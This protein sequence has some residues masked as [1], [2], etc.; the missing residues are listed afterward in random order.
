M[1]SSRGRG[2]HRIRLNCMVTNAE[3]H[4]LSRLSQLLAGLAH[5]PRSPGIVLAFRG[6]SLQK[7]TAHELPFGCVQGYEPGAAQ[8]SCTE[9]R[10][11]GGDHRKEAV[12]DW[13]MH[14]PETIGQNS[15]SS[16][17]DIDVAWSISKS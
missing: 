6:A 5:R 10:P 17:M 16:S 14:T 11:Y 7:G 1:N 15:V 8:G 3:V 13:I 2:T 9:S 12:E 4:F